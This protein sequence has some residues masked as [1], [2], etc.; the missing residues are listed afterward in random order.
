MWEL[1]GVDS[2]DINAME[3]YF[4]HFR[5]GQFKVVILDSLYRMLPAGI[6]EK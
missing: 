4:E 1:L 5:P 6:D 2:S 3:K